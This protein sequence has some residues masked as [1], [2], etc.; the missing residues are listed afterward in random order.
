MNLIEEEKIKNL[1]TMIK[2]Q[3]LVIISLLRRLEKLEKENRKINVTVS[4]MER[5]GAK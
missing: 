5:R 4:K 2:R 1:E 3:Q